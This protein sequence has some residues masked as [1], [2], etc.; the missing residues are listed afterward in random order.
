MSKYTYF[1]CIDIMYVE[2][3]GK[4]YAE[5]ACNIDGNN[6]FI[7]GYIN[8]DSY[9][10]GLLIRSSVGSFDDFN[11]CSELFVTKQEL[12]N[13]HE[14]IIEFMYETADMLDS[15]TYDNTK[16]GSITYTDGRMV[17]TNEY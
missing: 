3:H 12:G 17:W 6:L 11:N 8:Q 2:E 10:N 7:R 15:G 16:H 9:P 5:I 13:L 14:E 4:M 1:N